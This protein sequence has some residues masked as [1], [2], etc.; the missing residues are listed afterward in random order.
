M[1]N[2]VKVRTGQPDDVDSMM[3]LALSAVAENGLTDPS[4]VKL[5]NEIWAAL[6][7]ERGIV[8]VIGPPGGKLEAAILLRVDE[9]WYSSN[10]SLIERA[11]FVHPDYRSAKGGRARKLC[12]FA[13]QAAEAL[14][15]PL[16]IGVLSNQRTE[17]KMKLYQRVFG[18][19]AGCYFIWNG[20]TG[21]SQ[22]L[23]A[24]E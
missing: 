19:E 8:G 13:K 11:I 18:S 23:E 22:V 21:G 5:L 17:G 7:Q 24:A 16:V 20:K 4:P 10:S 12:D 15:I 6:N 9:L 14:E 2:I 3:E 1:D